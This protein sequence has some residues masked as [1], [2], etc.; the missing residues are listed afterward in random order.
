MSQDQGP[1]YICAWIDDDFKNGSHWNLNKLSDKITHVNWSPAQE[2]KPSRNVE[3][4]QFGQQVVLPTQKDYSTGKLRSWHTLEEI[5]C[6]E[7]ITNHCGMTVLWV[8]GRQHPYNHSKQTM[9]NQHM[10]NDYCGKQLCLHLSHSYSFLRCF[11]LLWGSLCLGLFD[12]QLERNSFLCVIYLLSKR[13]MRKSKVWLGLLYYLMACFNLLANPPKTFKNK[14]LCV[15][16]CHSRR[17]F[18]DIWWWIKLNI[19]L[20][21]LDM[22]LLNIEFLEFCVDIFD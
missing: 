21:I 20:N 6:T 22:R 4:V 17:K 11:S 2:T 15:C 5:N 1:L 12:S 14:F 18:L 8:I 9:E 3:R 19:S 7:T 10:N 16:V 13:N